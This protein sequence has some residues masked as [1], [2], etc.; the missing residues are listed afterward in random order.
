MTLTRETSIGYLSN[1]AARL[2]TRAI[3]RRLAPAG[4]ATAYLPVLFALGDGTAMTQKALAQRAAVE[5]PTMAATLKRMERDGLVQR[6]PDPA[7]RRS[8]LVALTPLASGQLDRVQTVVQQI[9]AMAMANL[10]PAEQQALLTH[11]LQ[12][13]AALEADEAAAQK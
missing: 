11:L 8:A 7:D 2:F 6:R 9:N 10:Q 4:I 1:W 13:I 3:E 12:V 5:Q